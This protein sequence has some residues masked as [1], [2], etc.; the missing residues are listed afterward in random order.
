MC[1]IVQSTFCVLVWHWF[2]AWCWR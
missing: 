2:L 1:E